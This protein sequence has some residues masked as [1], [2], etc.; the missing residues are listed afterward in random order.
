MKN[1]Y[2]AFI[3]AQTELENPHLD[4]SGYGYKYASLPKILEQVKPV[5]QKHGLGIIQVSEPTDGTVISIK[6]I[7]VHESGES[8]ESIMTMP[9]PD[10]KGANVTQKSGGAVTYIR[11]YAL[12]AILG[13]S[14]DEDTDASTPKKD[15]NGTSHSYNKNEKYITPGQ[16]KLILGLSK[17]IPLSVVDVAKTMG[18]KSIPDMTMSQ[19]SE[20]IERLQKRVEVAGEVH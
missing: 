8:I 15:G 5:L 10:I 11:R 3:K 19:A 4:S 20:C 16:V 12:T 14:G 17:K 18:V 1:L 13:I 2:T 7:L 9:I 6:T